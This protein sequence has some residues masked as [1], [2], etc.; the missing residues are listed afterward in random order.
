MMFGGGG[1]STE[2][3][4]IPTGLAETTGRVQVRSRRKKKRDLAR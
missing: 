4:P 3:S 2:K 1:V